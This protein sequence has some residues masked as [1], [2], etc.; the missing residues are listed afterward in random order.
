MVFS[1][2]GKRRYTD[3]N[4]LGQSLV[5]RYFLGFGDYFLDFL[6]T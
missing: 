4:K 5:Q 6:I 2:Q 3:F 1:T